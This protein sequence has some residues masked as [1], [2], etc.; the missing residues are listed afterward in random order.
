MT[1]VILNYDWSLILEAEL[2]D[3]IVREKS[4]R[5]R[6]RISSRRIIYTI[7]KQNPPTR[8]IKNRSIDM[9][10]ICIWEVIRVN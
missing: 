4:G 1:L 8:E 6:A 5:K 3:D 2:E 9:V 7:D 10:M